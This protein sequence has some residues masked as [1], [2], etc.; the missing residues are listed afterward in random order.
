MLVSSLVINTMFQTPDGSHA[1][2][3]GNLGTIDQPLAIIGGNCSMQGYNYEGDDLFWTV[4]THLKKSYHNI[5]S[6]S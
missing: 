5:S 4:S 6:L 2:V 3:I 1:V